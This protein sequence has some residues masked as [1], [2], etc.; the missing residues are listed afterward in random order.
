MKKK[1]ILFVFF[2]VSFF[3]FFLI[4]RGIPG[5]PEIKVIKNNLDQATKPFELSPE[6]G[7]YI[8]IVS[9]AENKSFSITKQMAD[10][11]YPD[12]G[13]FKGKF[14]VY[15]TPGVSL[16]ALPL[17]LLGRQYQ[18]AQVF[19]FSL[20]ALFAFLNI[21]LLFFICR[22]ICGFSVWL[23]FLAGLIFAFA[24][25]SLSY[26]VTLY[27][28]QISTFLLLS[29]F[30]AVWRYKQAGKLSW[31]WAFYVWLAYGIGIF[32]D[33]PNALL[34]LPVIAYLAIAAFGIK[35]ASREITISFRWSS[36]LSS[37][38]FIVLLVIHGY[39]NQVH[40][41]SFLRT[42]GGIVGYKEIKESN[43][44]G[45]PDS[46]K[47]IEKMASMKKETGFF[48]EENLPNGFYTLL[49]SGDRGLF[50]YSPIY[51]LAILGLVR[52][53]KKINL[54]KGI[55][56]SVIIINIFLYGSWGD[57]WGGWAFGPRYLIPSMAILSVFI[58]YWIA[59]LKQS[60]PDLLIAFL[61]FAYSL[62]IS[63]LGALTTNQVPPQVEADFL[64]MK[65]NFL[66][67]LD[68]LHDGKSGSFFYNTIFRQEISLQIYFSLIIAVILFMAAYTLYANY[69]NG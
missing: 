48:R 47:Q 64:N 17:Y 55:L 10:A 29:S 35:R 7:R 50:W 62:V 16:F 52:S 31:L 57:P 1:I 65:H 32:I 36:I 61:L 60:I 13:Y 58:A 25:T 37:V 51:L 2:A 30:W 22:K 67:N 12:V 24:S 49:F 44:F 9:L 3:I 54:E 38:I 45:K 8:L 23:S 66:L 63:L 40:F 68:Y 41:G 59:E 28:H 19:T 46:E 53:L 27:Q 39:Y 43:I 26:A 14:Y 4:L 69:R 5:N 56:V 11:A 34:F 42:S 20:S 15:F 6:R 18:L 21:I 33:Y